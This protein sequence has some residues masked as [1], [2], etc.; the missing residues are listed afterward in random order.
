MN[1]SQHY[2]RAIQDNT[3]TNAWQRVCLLNPKKKIK[4]KPLLLSLIK[5]NGKN[6]KQLKKRQSGNRATTANRVDGSGRVN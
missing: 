4:Q 1:L 3:L 2:S 6:I 5:W